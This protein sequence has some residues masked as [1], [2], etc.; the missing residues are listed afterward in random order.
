MGNRIPRSFKCIHAV[1]LVNSSAFIAGTKVIITKSERG[2]YHV[3]G[4]NEIIYNAFPAHLRNEA[5]FR[6]ENVIV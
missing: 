6:F 1:T 3:K 2:N 5:F 4:P